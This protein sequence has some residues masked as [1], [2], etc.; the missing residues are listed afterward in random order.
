MNHEDA[1]STKGSQRTSLKKQEFLRLYYEE[2]AMRAFRLLFVLLTLAFAAFAA[3]KKPWKDMYL[4]VGDIKM[5]YLDAG[6]GTR[7]LIFVPGLMMIAE[8]WKE[9]ISYFTARGFHVLA[10]DPRSQGLTTKTEA[11]NTYHQQAADLFVFL[12]N[13][14]IEHPILVGW[15]AGVTVLLEY[16]SSPE[17][18][19]PEFLV[20]VDGAPTLLNQDDYTYGQTMQQARNMLL[21]IED[22]RAKFAD[23]FVR[24]MFKSRQPELL[25]QEILTGSSKTP[26]GTVVALFFDLFTGD[27]RSALPRVTVPTLIVMTAERRALGEY[28]QAKIPRSKLE[29]IPDAGHALFLEKP[30]AFNQTL[31]KFFGEQ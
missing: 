25:Y 18:L 24:G 29:V 10:I 26:T 4:Q 9:Q 31:E 6:S 23:Q 5:H 30:Q 3:E 15:S 1:K 16:I 27:R 13:L 21:S 7:Q 20:L 11:G 22:D 14:G 19:Q 8:V 2:G 28:M 17:T 12:K